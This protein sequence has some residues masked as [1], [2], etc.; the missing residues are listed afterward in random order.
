MSHRLEKINELILQQLTMLIR[1][2]FPGEII[3][4]NFV[5]TNT[6][7]SESKIYLDIASGNDRVFTELVANSN[8]YRRA[9][10]EKLF[11]RKMP[12]L[13]FIR[14]KM[15]DSVDRIEKILQSE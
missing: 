6:D 4:I 12:K 14:D 3:T 5:F 1:D 8:E 10:A 15:Q 11:L 13:T 2:D 9:L 7:L